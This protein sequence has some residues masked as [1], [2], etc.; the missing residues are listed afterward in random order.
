MSRR[1]D[2]EKPEKKD[3]IDP[4][5]AGAMSQAG[6]SWNTLA[7]IRRQTC[8]NCGFVFSLTYGRT[9]AC[10][11]CPMATKNCPKV[12]CAKCD[13]EYYISEMSHVAGSEVAERAVI[14]HQSHVENTYNEQ[15]GRKR[16]R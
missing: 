13:H 6:V 8:P 1:D 3:R 15:I 4:F 11:G 14:K 2:E 9:I 10:R 12:R 5:Y 16:H 7:T